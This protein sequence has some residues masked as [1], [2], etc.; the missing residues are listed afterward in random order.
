MITEWALEMTVA[1]DKL[2]NAPE[3][4]RVG[5]GLQTMEKLPG[6]KKEKKPVPEIALTQ[7]SGPKK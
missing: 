4:I 2:D 5:V 7:S 6:E 3:N 1:T